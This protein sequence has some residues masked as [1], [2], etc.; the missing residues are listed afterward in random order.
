MEDL[1]ALLAGFMLI[2]FIV[3]LVLYI[4]GSLGLAGIT[5][6]VNEKGG[7]MAW[8]PIFNFYLIGKLGFSKV[9]GWA[10][11]V[12]SFLSSKSTTTVNGVSV[13][14]G[15]ILPTQL[16]SIAS[17][18]LFILLIVSLFKIYSKVSEKAVVMIIC[19][20]LSFGLLA[21]IFL[22]AIRKNEAIA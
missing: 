16:A 4:L 22:F 7:W 13:T 3:F 15:T 10:M 9:V 21:P 17:F 20:V 11:V 6:N 2:F 12:L 14:T 8:F 1:F 19:T 18:A 5:K